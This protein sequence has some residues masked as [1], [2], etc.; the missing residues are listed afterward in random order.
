MYIFLLELRVKVWYGI[1]YFRQYRP[2]HHRMFHIH[3][4]IFTSSDPTLSR[5]TGF[6]RIHY[7]H[8]SDQFSLPDQSHSLQTSRLNLA[9]SS[10]TPAVENTSKDNSL[11]NSPELLFYF[12]SIYLIISLEKCSSVPANCS[13]ASL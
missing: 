13:R 4:L 12:V 1:D 3:T 11:P 6:G 10:H 8:T 5:E 9:S 2:L 7:L